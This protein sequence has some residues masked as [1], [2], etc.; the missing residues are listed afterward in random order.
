M[1]YIYFG[2]RINTQLNNKLPNKLI[3]IYDI[4]IMLW[5]CYQYELKEINMEFKNSV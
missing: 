3:C 1:C 5:E 4:K 2:G